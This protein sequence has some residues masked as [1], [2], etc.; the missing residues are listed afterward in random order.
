VVRRSCCV[1]GLGLAL[2]AL[3]AACGATKS[4][5]AKHVANKSTTSESIAPAVTGPTPVTTSLV[6]P[7]VV[8]GVSF[9]TVAYVVQYIQTGYCTPNGVAGACEVKENEGPSG[10]D[11]AAGAYR[12]VKFWLCAKSQI[13]CGVEGTNSE[14]FVNVAGFSTVSEATAYLEGAQNAWATGWQLNQWAIE[15]STNLPVN[16][17]SKVERSL[18]AAAVILNG[19]VAAG[20]S[21]RM[22]LKKVF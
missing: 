22:E 8:G 6:V 3:L 18:A 4:T 5:T 7:Q 1:L 17:L 19:H 9:Q 14:G 2:V 20:D 21:N 16:E 13:A 10:Q 12:T 15:V 11:A